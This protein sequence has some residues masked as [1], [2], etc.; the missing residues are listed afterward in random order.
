MFGLG[1]DTVKDIQGV[2]DQIGPIQKVLLYGSRAMGNYKA[3][4]DVDI[5]LIGHELTQNNS[6]Y[7][8]SKKLDDLCLP[9]EFD[10]SIFKDLNDL[11]LVEHI[12]RVGKV[13]YQRK[14]E[15]PWPIVELGE[16]IT[17]EYGK[18]LPQEDRTPNGK[19]PVYGAN[20]IKTRSNKYFCNQ[21]SIILGRK[22]SAG[23][24]NLTSKKFWPLDVTYYTIFDP[25]KYNL[26]FLY[27]SMKIL[28][29]K[30]LAKGVKPGIN[31]ND[32]YSKK[33]KIPPLNHQKKIV[34]TLDKASNT[35]N[36]AIA[37]TE[38]NLQNCREF[39]DSYTGQ[40]LSNDNGKWPMV[41][42]SEVCEISSG[43][44]PKRSIKKYWGGKIPWI[45]SS[46][47][48]DTK[49]ET[50]KEFITNEGLNNSSSKILKKNTTLIALVGATIGRTGFLN[51]DCAT[52]QNIAGLYPKDIKNLNSI[53][54]FNTVKDLYP[55]F[56]ELGKKDFKMANLGF[57]KKQSIP[58]PPLKYQK[59][60]VAKIDKIKWE[61][62]LLVEIYQK[63]L[64][65]LKELKQA[66][67]QRVLDGEIAS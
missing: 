37:H 48:K 66:I 38:Q 44:T 46:A 65:C 1:V 45:G 24:V 58:L 6:F 39:F 15:P 35:L 29:L 33:V 53:Y 17:L 32:V 59:E 67:F 49:I 55:K 36:K 50:A 63:K 12:L 19:F 42:L 21:K 31:R 11:N 47:C 3:G 54:L 8:L 61:N 13:L 34:V 56:L 43:G 27:Q 62:D 41:E 9:Y 23:E 26:E 25:L 2:I 14:T 10:I 57:V 64:N 28:D 22:G 20:G 51:F 18:P 52:N 30:K 16:V 7:P 60:I 5:T 4:S 40:L